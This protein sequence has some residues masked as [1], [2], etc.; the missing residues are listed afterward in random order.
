MPLSHTSVNWDRVNPA[1]E[2]LSCWSPGAGLPDMQGCFDSPPRIPPRNHGKRPCCRLADQAPSRRH[3]SGPR[4][5]AP[6]CWNRS[7]RLQ[8]PG[9]RRRAVWERHAAN[10][11]QP[12]GRKQGRC[13]L[14]PAH[15]D[16]RIQ[17]GW[18]EQQGTRRG[19]W[20]Q[21]GTTRS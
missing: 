12:C 3:I 16:E 4:L 10:Q 9:K 13:S 7:E 14:V 2:Q 17:Q 18:P 8:G 15:R 20:S 5:A 21:G 19:M 1:C 11:Q 6:A